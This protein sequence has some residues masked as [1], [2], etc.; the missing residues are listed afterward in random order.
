MPAP[1]TSTTTQLVIGRT[2]RCPAG[3]TSYSTGPHT[4][5]GPPPDRRPAQQLVDQSRV[6]IAPEFTLTVSPATA[7][8]AALRRRDQRLRRTLVKDGPGSLALTG[9]N[10]Y[11]GGTL[12]KAHAY[13]RQR[14]SSATTGSVAGNID[15]PARRRS[16]STARR[17][18]VCRAIL[19]PGGA[20][21]R[22]RRPHA[23]RRQ[24]LHGGTTINWGSTLAVS[25]NANLGDASGALTLYGGTLRTT[26]PLAGVRPRVVLDYYGGAIDTHGFDSVF[27]GQFTG[28]GQLKKAGAGVLTLTNAGNAFGG[29][30]TITGGT[31]RIGTDNTLPTGG[32]VFVGDSGTLDVAN[33]Q[34]TAYLYGRRRR[35]PLRR[36][37]P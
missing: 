20:D 10:T 28:N 5:G 36:R 22:L 21:P 30:V 29:Q 31:L 12:V 24:H 6:I 1:A 14:Q 3:R 26:A 23:C 34:T 32:T 2:T 7:K 25:A 37:R 27:S 4:P 19:A 33:N 15:S 17:L 35:Q 16:C 13:P 9:D 18:H 11:G 8:P